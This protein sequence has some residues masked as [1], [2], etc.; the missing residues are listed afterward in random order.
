MVS[1]IFTQSVS[2][3]ELHKWNNPPACQA[4]VTNCGILPHKRDE[5]RTGKKLPYTLQHYCLSLFMSQ[6][7]FLA[8]LFLLSLVSMAVLLWL[9]SRLT[10]YA[11]DRQ[12]VLLQRFFGTAAKT[13]LKGKKEMDISKIQ[14]ENGTAEQNATENFA[15]K[16]NPHQ[17]GTVLK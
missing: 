10:R 5:T 17:K 16:R 2:T 1:L 7:K 4:A 3:Q 15:L 13:I 11:K 9:R 6:D 12:G 8:K 14:Y